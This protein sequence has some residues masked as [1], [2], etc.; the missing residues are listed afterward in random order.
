M[1]RKQAERWI[2]ELKNLMAEQMPI[3]EQLLINHNQ[4]IRQ[5]PSMQGLL[6]LQEQL[7]RKF[8]ELKSYVEEKYGRQVRHTK[9]NRQTSSIARRQS[10]KSNRPTVTKHRTSQDTSSS[11][12]RPNSALEIPEIP[13]KV[14]KF[15]I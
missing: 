11:G 4:L 6:P 8:H 12:S 3:L 1:D 14:F 7:T 10:K 5:N 2:E 9:L 13:M 15:K